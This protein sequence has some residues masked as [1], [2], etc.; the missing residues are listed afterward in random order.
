MQTWG[1]IY[2]EIYAPVVSY[3]SVRTLLVLSVLH[4]LE[5]RLIKF[6]LSFPQADLDLDVFMELPPG[7]DI[8]GNTSSYVIELNKSLY[9]LY[10]S[11][12]KWWHRLKSS[13]ESTGYANQSTADP[14]FPYATYQ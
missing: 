12:H 11:S 10:Q 2:W 14:C 6:T 7:L 8:G 9:S 1:E 13:L 5:S 3:L 4:D